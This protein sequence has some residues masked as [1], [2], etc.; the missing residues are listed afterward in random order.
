LREAVITGDMESFKEI[1][2]SKK[3]K[4]D[5]KDQ[6]GSTVLV[7]TCNVEFL[8]IL[9]DYGLDLNIKNQDDLTGLMFAARH[10][11]YEAVE[12]YLNHGVDVNAKKGSR[13]ALDNATSEKIIELL[14]AHGAR[15]GNE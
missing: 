4:P 1:L 12:F 3:A 2:E 14:I 5:A 10:G 13:T 6:F 11:C 9:F 15:K 8:S 7:Y